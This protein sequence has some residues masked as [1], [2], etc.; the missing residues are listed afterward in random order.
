MMVP[1]PGF[2]I[3]GTIGLVTELIPVAGMIVAVMVKLACCCG[4]CC[5]WGKL[6]DKFENLFPVVW[7]CVPNIDDMIE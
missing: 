7:L 2:E 5:C 1:F 3:A 6:T 4:C